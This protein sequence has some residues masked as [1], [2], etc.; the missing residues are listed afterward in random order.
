MPVE[1]EKISLLDSL[2]LL[3]HKGAV[4]D[5]GFGNGGFALAIAKQGWRCVGLEFTEK[6]E[7]PFDPAGRFE[8]LMGPDSLEKLEAEQFDLITMWH[9][10]EH[11]SDPIG[12]LRQARRVLRPGGHIV[13]AVPNFAGLSSRVFKRNW[14][15]LSPPWH[16]QQFSPR[17]LGLA[18]CEAGILLEELRGFGELAMRI[19]WI[20]SLTEM[21]NSIPRVWYQSTLRA[22]LRVVRRAMA[23]VPHLLLW[24]ERA[25]GLPGAMVAIGRKNPLIEIL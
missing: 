24:T 4:L 2:G 3:D 5:I 16:L 9:V 19:C 21:M 12:T 23:T 10:L 1:K 7:L 25:C 6:V 15:A 20:G 11:I 17:S 22:A 13:T 8:V 14:Y 18:F